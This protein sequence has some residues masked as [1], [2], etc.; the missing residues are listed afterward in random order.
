MERITATFEVVTP[1]FLGGAKRDAPAELRAPSVKGALRFWY[2]AIDP[3]YRTDEP[4]IFGDPTKQHGQS[5]VLVTIKCDQQ[6]N[7]PWDPSRHDLTTKEFHPCMPVGISPERQG[8]YELNGVR[9]FS[10]MGLT[11]RRTFPVTHLFAIELLFKPDL[12]VKHRRQIISSLWLFCQ[13]G[14]LGA[15]SRR[16]FGSFSLANIDAEG[17]IPEVKSLP[18]L[19]PVANPSEWIA[20]FNE[21][22]KVMHKWLGNAASGSHSVLGPSAKIKL[23]LQ[24]SSTWAQAFR[25]AG[26][27]MQVF[28]QRRRPDYDDVKAHICHDD[29][30]AAA[31]NAGAKNPI[32]PAA[33]TTA[34][35]RVAFGLPLTFR[36]SSLE[37]CDRPSGWLRFKDNDDPAMTTPARTFQGI[38][39]GI[40][41]DR[42]ASPIHVRIVKIGNNFHPLYLH[43]AAPL[44]DNYVDSKRNRLA[45]PDGSILEDFWKSLPPSAEWEWKS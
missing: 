39:D 22:F 34:P 7:T 36:Y 45:A 11:G 32:T 31:I 17:D 35:K 40:E 4:K 18:F 20:R 26:R 14:G 37:H 23:F 19:S 8:T 25:A 43:M 9:Y 41:R 38:A 28:R 10:L 16:A 30:Q 5:S 13:L 24:P 3:E 1:M 21:G 44:C 42:Y 27:E 12:A 15:R 33:L 2:R 29:T 6:G